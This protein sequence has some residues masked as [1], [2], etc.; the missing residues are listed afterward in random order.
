M[1]DHFLPELSSVE[2]MA[3]LLPADRDPPPVGVNWA[4]N[5][6]KHHEEK[7]TRFIRTYEYQKIQY[8]DPNLICGIACDSSRQPRPSL[9]I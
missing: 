6:V 7:K 5:F 4:L 1:R 2:D 9:A 8:E 3:N